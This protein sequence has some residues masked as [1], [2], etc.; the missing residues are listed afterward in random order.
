MSKARALRKFTHCQGL[1]GQDTKTSG[2]LPA[3]LC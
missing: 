1:A 3:E 2:V